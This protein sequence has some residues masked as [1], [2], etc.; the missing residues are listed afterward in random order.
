MGHCEKSHLLRG[1]GLNVSL[2]ALP[3]WKPDGWQEGRQSSEGKAKLR[4][5]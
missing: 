1:I 4:A 3:T 2:T 5:L